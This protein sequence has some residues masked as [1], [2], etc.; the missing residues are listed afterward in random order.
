[1]DNLNKE[2]FFN[3]LMEKYPAATKDFCNWIDKY[4]DANFWDRLFGN[5]YRDDNSTWIKFHHIPIEMQLGIILRYFSDSIGRIQYEN[6]LSPKDCTRFTLASFLFVRKD[7]IEVITRTFGA[8]EIKLNKSYKKN[9]RLQ[10][11]PESTD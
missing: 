6:P 5:N 7:L 1:M 2:N 8:I 9:V 3:E 4:K 10:Q 11:S